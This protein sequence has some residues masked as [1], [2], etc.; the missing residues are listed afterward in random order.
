MGIKNQTTDNLFKA[1]LKLENIEECY[2]F[3]EDLCTV[4]EIL[5]MSQR[6][7][8]ALQLDAKKNYQQIAES[9][10]AS[11]ATI[12]RVNK[13]YMYGKD[14]YKKIIDRLKDEKNADR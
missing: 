5:D 13:S 14:G 10:G 2:D 1:I 3:F 7:D 4:K 9:S 8:V 6:F 11:T 12:S